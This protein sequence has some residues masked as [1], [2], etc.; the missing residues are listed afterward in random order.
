MFQAVVGSIGLGPEG[1]TFSFGV[2][3]PGRGPRVCLTRSGAS[4]LCP[5][6]P[7]LLASGTFEFRSVCIR[8]FL[9]QSGTRPRQS[10]S[11]HTRGR[12][13]FTFAEASVP[14]SRFL[15]SSLGFFLLLASLL[16][17][18]RSGNVSCHCLWADEEKYTKRLPEV[19]AIPLDTATGC[20][21]GHTEPALNLHRARSLRLQW[22]VSSKGVKIATETSSRVEL[23]TSPN[24]VGDCRVAAASL[25]TFGKAATLTYLRSAVCAWQVKT[26]VK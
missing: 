7:S 17:G 21:A 9:D 11:F 19:Q 16:V 4:R 3:A 10:S 15:R 20:R 14:S 12:E 6:G 18:L 5:R 13:V 8:H 22:T 23:R 24:Q 25:R 2:G 26:R 1:L